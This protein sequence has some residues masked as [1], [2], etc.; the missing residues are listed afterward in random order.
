MTTAR[1]SAQ[2]PKLSKELE[3]KA[4]PSP[5]PDSDDPAYE[6]TFKLGDKTDPRQWSTARKW[7]I[8]MVALSTQLWANVISAIYAPSA[9][10][11]AEEFGI[12]PTVSR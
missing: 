10:G 6:V 7:Q 12:S 11:V 2:L 5:S 4:S 9:V 1:N 3:E 8:L